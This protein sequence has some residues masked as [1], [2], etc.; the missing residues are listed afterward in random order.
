MGTYC[1]PLIAD[2]FLFCCESDFTACLSYNKEAEI[3]Q[4]FNFT[5][6]YPD[7]LLNFDNSYFEGTMGRIYPP[8]LQL[9]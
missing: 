8:E 4:A 3:I 1:A 6:R 9:N 7:D 2:L 5:S